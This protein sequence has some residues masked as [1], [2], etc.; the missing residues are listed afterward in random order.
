MVVI[1]PTQLLPSFLFK[2]FP[3]STE[4]LRYDLVHK[5]SIHDVGCSPLL[6]SLSYFHGFLKRCILEVVASDT[7][8][9]PMFMSRPLTLLKIMSVCQSLRGFELILTAA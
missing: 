9:P 3:E 7:L 8:T 4:L 5:L 1:N 2:P 6:F